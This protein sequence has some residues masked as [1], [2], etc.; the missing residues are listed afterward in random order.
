MEIGNPAKKTEFGQFN[1]INN[2]PTYSKFFTIFNWDIEGRREGVL[3]ARSQMKHIKF[4]LK[5]D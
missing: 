4:C 2:P 3:I 1:V 5:E